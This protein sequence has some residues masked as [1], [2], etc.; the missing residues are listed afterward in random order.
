MPH[1]RNQTFSIPSK[2][3]LDISKKYFAPHLFS[4]E[5]LFG[6]QLL[7]WAYNSCRG[8]LGEVIQTCY[9]LPCFYNDCLGFK[10]LSAALSLYAFSFQFLMLKLDQPAIATS[11]SFGKYEKSHVCNLRKFKVY[12]GLN[13]EYMTELLT[14]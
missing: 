6:S 5:S 14:G 3:W 7:Q 11:I 2:S 13:T 10:N 4:P 8:F 12:G 1:P 9:L